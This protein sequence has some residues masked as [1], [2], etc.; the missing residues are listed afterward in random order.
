MLRKK[1]GTPVLLCSELIVLCSS[2]EAETLDTVAMSS[3]ERRLHRAKCAPS[4]KL[5]LPAAHAC[6]YHLGAPFHACSL[7]LSCPA[8]SA[9]P[10]C[11]LLMPLRPGSAHSVCEIAISLMVASHSGLTSCFPWDGPSVC[12][13][14]WSLSSALLY[15]RPSHPPPY[16]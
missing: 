9:G 16:V 14:L 3:W 10:L 6:R 1:N 7:F 8:W 4:C 11:V 15:L 13:F 12:Y 2:K 5:S